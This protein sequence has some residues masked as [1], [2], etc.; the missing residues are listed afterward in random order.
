MAATVIDRALAEQR[1]VL[2]EIE[3][4]ELIAQAGIPVVEARLARTKAEAIAFSKAIGFP[5]VL[6]IVAPDVI[7][8]S[9]AGGV[10]LGLADETQVGVAYAEVVAAAQQAHPGAAIHGVSV[11]R[12]ARP[13]AEV[14]VGMFKDAQFGPV[15]MFGLGGVFV[16]ILKDVA[17]GIVPLLP[18]DASRMINEIK[19]A[20]LLRGFRGQE[21]ADLR[22]LE[23]ILLRLSEFVDRTPEIK[24]VD[25]NPIF[26]Y[27]DGAVAVDA[28]VILE[29]Q[30][31]PVQRHAAAASAPPVRRFGEKFPPQSIAIVGVSQKSAM[32]APG[33]TGMTFLR[34]LREAGFAGNLYPINPHLSEIDGLKV[35]PSVTAVPEPP[36]LAIVAVPATGVPKVLE[37]CVAAQV[38]NVHI[39]T[40]GF[41]ETGEAEGKIL[42]DRLR[43]IAVRGG[44]RVIGPNCI[45]FHVPSARIKMFEELELLDGPVAFL[46]Q[47]GGHAI[48]FLKH[49]PDFGFGLSTLISYGNALTLDAPD[50]V[51]YLAGDPDTQVICMYTEGV[52][53]GRRLF[54][55]VRRTNPVK[56]VVIWKSGLSEAG[57]RAAASHTASLGGDRQV[58]DAFFRQTGAI[59]V[60]STEEMA[61]VAMTLLHENRPRGHRAVVLSGG[62]GN[63]VATGDICAQEG[64]ALPPLS[65]QTKAAL[66]AFVSSVNQG[67]TN[68]MDVPGVLTNVSMLRRV[69]DVLVADEIVDVIILHMAAVFFTEEL[70][71]G[72]SEFY[73]VMTQT[74]QR[75]SASKP[76][77]MA[78]D[79]AYPYEGTEMRAREFR[80]A[81]VPAY[82]SIRSACRAL[83]RVADYLPVPQD[84]RRGN[85]KEP[86]ASAGG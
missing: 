9:D 5:V 62:G 28:R 52:R 22:A 46:S 15:L 51:E 86:I 77:V 33:F 35:Y 58:W 29:P 78:L 25:L 17:F 83:R 45:G 31:E 49:A 27:R 81:G 56:P 79:T 57:A 11:Q 64:L 60:G 44:L 8:K 20:A 76:I 36:D 4:K 54:N 24:E 34:V 16:E 50:F 61:E 13:G 71:G 48:N 85:A 10:K 3:S 21:A 32:G 40:S 19:G 12:M 47:S 68:P 14:I 18:E 69:L 55:L 37:E 53:D 80:K 74:A 75:G 63:N 82:V 42:E 7:H 39:C 72:V 1:T 66:Q 26:A 2:T 70:A 6:K 30:A 84:N 38:A 43:E 41:A 23:T 67:L 73:K 59:S 65:P